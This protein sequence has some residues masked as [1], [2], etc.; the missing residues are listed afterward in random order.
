[1]HSWRCISNPFLIHRLWQFLGSHVAAMSYS[2]CMHTLT[3]LGVL[4]GF[5]GILGGLGGS[6]GVLGGSEGDVRG[7]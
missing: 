1:M 2:L 6:L 4:G 5:G 7:I 3:H